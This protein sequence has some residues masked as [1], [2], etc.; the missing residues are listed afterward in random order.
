MELLQQFW[1]EREDSLDDTDKF[2]RYYILSQAWKDRGSHKRQIPVEEELADKEDSERDGEMDKYEEAY[3]FRYEDG[4]GAFIQTHSRQP[5]DTLRLKQNTR[6][7]KRKQRDARK[8]DEK[9]SS[10][11]RMQTRQMSELERAKALKLEELTRKL[12]TI[13][14]VAGHQKLE[15]LKPELEGA[16]EPAQYDQI[17]EKVFDD[18][19]YK[20]PDSH[21]EQGVDDQVNQILLKDQIDQLPN[22]LA[23]AQAPP[24]KS[25]ADRIPCW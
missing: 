9:V 17:V 4:S 13:A 22:A 19:Y 21:F 23:Q 2:L 11:L 7:D 1:G 3:N 10:L 16:F 20:Q 18:T 5:E 24:Q 12:D 6:Q 15:L 8:Q 25:V 14:K